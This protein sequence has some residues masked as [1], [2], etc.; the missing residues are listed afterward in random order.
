MPF[1]PRFLLP[2]ATTF[3]LA[4]ALVAAPVTLKVPLT[5]ARAAVAAVKAR[6][7]LP[8]G[9]VIV[10][11]AAGTY[12]LSA[13]LALTAADGGTTTAPI[14]WRAAPGA[15]VIVSG[16]RTLA[17]WQP[18]TDPAILARLPAASRAQVLTADLRAAGITDFGKFEQRG[19]PGLELFCNGRRQQLARYPNEGWLLTAGVPQTGA[20]RFNEGLERE[21]RYDGVPVGRHYGRITYDGDRPASWAPDDEIYAQGYWVWDWNDSFQRIQSIDPARREITFAEPHHGYGYAPR[22]R[23]RYLNVLEELDQPGEWY[24]DRKAGRVYFYPPAPLV[25]GAVVVS[26]LAA[27]LL[28]LTDVAYVSLE[29]FIFEHSRGSGVVITGGADNQVAGCIFRE[30]GGEALVI[31]GGARHR[32]VSCDFHD[33][34]LGAIRVAGGDRATL[35]PSHHEIINNHIH[36]Y[37]QWLRTGQYGVLL[38]G[39]GQRVAHNRIHD[40][41]FEGMYQRGNDHLLEFNEVYR[42]CTETGDAGA[43]HTGRDFTWQGNVIR[44]NYWHDLQGPGLHGVTAV[45]LDDFSSGYEIYGNVFYRAGRAVELGGG[46]DNTVANNLFVECNPAVHLDA[47]G[48]GWARNYFNGEFTW[49]A[50][51]FRE[52]KGDQPPYATRYPRLKTLLQDEPAVPKG[53]VV[54]NNV[55]WGAGRWCDVYDFYAFDFAH[56][57]TMR[58]NLVADAGFMRRRA[59]PETAMDP[60]YLNIDGKEGYA[61]LPTDNADTR[62]EFPGNELTAQ[63][64]GTFDPVAL[65]F[66]PRDPAALKRIGFVPPPLGQMGLQLDSWRTTIPARN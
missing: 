25:P 52:M 4:P 54:R 62:G 43:I 63:P 37:S 30:L 19:S 9:G 64:P 46:R 13:P 33:L 11:I 23:F 53:N 5:E 38:D 47:R 48:L 6:G 57:I 61:L 58:D 16:G 34:A 14:V 65:S 32:V 50:D 12:V 18:V 45:Y 35:T 41:P 31:T 20:K 55:S 60:Y 40:A 8:E 59:R 1:T 39:V 3:L 36:D 10:E 7:P 15:Q 28:T 2:F 56:T 29:G 51:R 26:V 22:Q 42:V 44:Y 24:L 66:T 17:D 49:L 27:P 21:K